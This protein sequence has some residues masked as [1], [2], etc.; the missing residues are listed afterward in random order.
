M[1]AMGAEILH[2]L[3]AT[4]SPVGSVALD[5]Y[6]D[7]IARVM[8]RHTPGAPAAPRIVTL[9]GDSIRTL[10][11][12]PDTILISVGLL[13]ALDDEAELAFVVAHELAHLA[14]ED[15]ERLLIRLG[16]RTLS[17]GAEAAGT[18]AW[19]QAGL[20]LTCFG[21]GNA[22]ER[23]ADAIATAAVV[24]AGYDADAIRRLLNRLERRVEAGDARVAELFFAHPP[25]RDRLRQT[26]RTLASLVRRPALPKVNR[27]PFRRAAGPQALANLTPAKIAIPASPEV[28]AR[29]RGRVWRRSAWVVGLLAAVVAVVWFF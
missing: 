23:H 17:R 14:S 27:E 11:L 25:P 12:P 18:E 9:R 26:E 2:A 22:R 4:Y 6:L 13:E 1:V 19:R 21:Y 8:S 5:D 7:R 28:S 15:P 3:T 10:A 29:F 16:L 20:D 24:E